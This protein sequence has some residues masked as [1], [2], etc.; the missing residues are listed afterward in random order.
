[1]DGNH[2]MRCNWSWVLCSVISSCWIEKK[3]AVISIGAQIARIVSR[4]AGLAAGVYFSNS[5][6]QQLLLGWEFKK[7]SLLSIIPKL[8][9]VK[10]EIHDQLNRL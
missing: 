3:G 9:N 5:H 2:G 7:K 4:R 1:M 8:K 6:P 10:Y